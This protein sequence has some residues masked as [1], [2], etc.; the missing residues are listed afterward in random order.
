MDLNLNIF[1][2]VALYLKGNGFQKKSILSI[3][4][5]LPVTGDFGLKE[6]AGVSFISLFIFTNVIIS[7]TNT[8][9]PDP[10]KAPDGLK[11]ACISGKS[12]TM[13]LNVG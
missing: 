5:F 7:I 6:S 8:I 2:R 10:N 3:S 9:I 12:I 11:S 13:D 4:I 1:L